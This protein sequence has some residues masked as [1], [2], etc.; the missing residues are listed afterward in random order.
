MEKKIGELRGKLAQNEERAKEEQRL[1]EAA[2][3]DAEQC[4]KI[5]LLEYLKACHHFHRA[6]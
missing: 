1:R 6:L 4:Q 2:E 5:N 3:A